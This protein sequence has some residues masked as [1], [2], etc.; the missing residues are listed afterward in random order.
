[1][2]SPCLLAFWNMNTLF[3]GHKL[4]RLESVDSTN[5]FAAK[6]VSLPDWVEGTAIVAEEQH[7]GKGRHDRTWDSEP[8]KNLTV[9]FLFK[10]HF[11][12]SQQTFLLQ[13]FSALAVADTL[14]NFTG[15][16]PRIKWPND[17]Y[18]GSKKIAGILNGTSFQGDSFKSAIIGIGVNVN[19]TFFGRYN[20]TS[21]K[22]ERAQDFDLEE[23]FGRLC[24]MLE[25]R[26]LQL[27]RSDKV[28]Q[29]D[30]HDQL[31]GLGEVR[32]YSFRGTKKE[33]VLQRVDEEGN[34]HFLTS[35]G[36]V[37]CAIDD[38]TW[39]W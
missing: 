21:L 11:L 8:G 29:R 19:Q 39:I 26:Y 9:S 18:V 20:A 2:K 12:N 14:K 10:P 3:V 15:T 36:A 16:Q 22:N 25:K 6:L 7:G 24:E 28:I 1:M 31:F 38:V 30:Y 37:N 13:K 34:A 4:I 5:K 17:I 32:M 23:L 33:A 35:S 27:K